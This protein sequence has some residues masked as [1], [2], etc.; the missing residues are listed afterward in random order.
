MFWKKL[1][2]IHVCVHEQNPSYAQNQFRPSTMEICFALNHGK[3]SSFSRFSQGKLVELN[4]NFSVE[5]KNLFPQFSLSFLG[6]QLYKWACSF[7][8]NAAIP[9]MDFIIAQKISFIILNFYL[10]E[11]LVTQI[12]RKFPISFCGIFFYNF[13]WML[14]NIWKSWPTILELTF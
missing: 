11:N 5:Q 1:Q 3:I 7:W 4:I 14:T 8:G 10:K 9:N 2:K 6:N 13:R 12:C